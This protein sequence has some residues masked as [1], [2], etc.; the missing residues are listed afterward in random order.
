MATLAAPSSIPRYFHPT[1][2]VPKQGTRV[3]TSFQVSTRAVVVWAGAEW[4]PPPAAPSWPLFLAVGGKYGAVAKAGAEREVVLFHHLNLL[5]CFAKRPLSHPK[6]RKTEPGLSCASPAPNLPAR[7]GQS[8]YWRVGRGSTSSTARAQIAATFAA[9]QSRG[10]RAPRPA[11][12]QHRPPAARTPGSLAGGRGGGR[13]GRKDRPQLLA[14]PEPVSCSPSPGCERPE[15]PPRSRAV[16]QFPPPRGSGG[17]WRGGDGQSI[18][19]NGDQGSVVP[20]PRVPPLR[21]GQGGDSIPPSG[22][23]ARGENR[24]R[25]TLLRQLGVGGLPKPRGVFGVLMVGERSAP[26]CPCPPCPRDAERG[27]SVAAAALCRRLP[28]PQILSRGAAGSVPSPSLLLFSSSPRALPLSLLRW[29][30][31]ACAHAPVSPA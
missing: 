4:V 5:V 15:G 26:P 6:F 21:C 18:A 19:G 27:C 12:S 29:A 7:G 14:E 23:S 16:P 1:G 8:C 9:A 24:P 11:R 28:P 2:A 10:P 20:Q 3:Q 30:H 17:E 31:P 13:R 22:P 25:P